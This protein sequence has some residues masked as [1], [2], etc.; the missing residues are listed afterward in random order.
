M[1]VGNI[2]V[3]YFLRFRN[4]ESC[5]YTVQSNVQNHVHFFNHSLAHGVS[6]DGVICYMHY[7]EANKCSDIVVLAR[8]VVLLMTSFIT[9]Y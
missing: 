7:T 9:F 6:V 1:Q 5:N 3:C 8:V 4:V 2:A